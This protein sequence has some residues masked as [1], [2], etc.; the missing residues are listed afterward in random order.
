MGE[1]LRNEVDQIWNLDCDHV[2]IFRLSLGPERPRH[3]RTTQ[4]PM[5]IFTIGFCGT[6][7]QK[8]AACPW[9]RPQLRHDY[10]DLTG[11]YASPR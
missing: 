7:S 5:P 6:F 2:W 1:N 9:F 4:P 11:G 10:V 3:A 8:S